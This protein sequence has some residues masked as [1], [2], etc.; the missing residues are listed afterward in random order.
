MTRS[1]D[2]VPYRSWHSVRHRLVDGV[3]HESIV[4]PLPHVNWAFDLRHVE[5]PTPIEEFSIADEP[6]AA[7]SEAFGT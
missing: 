3:R 2:R 4:K 1:L 5:S 6:V 7:M